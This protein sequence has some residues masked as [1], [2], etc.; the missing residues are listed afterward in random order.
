[1]EGQYKERGVPLSVLNDKAGEY[2]KTP[3]IFSLTQAH[4]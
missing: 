3:L 4:K 2:Q 1:M